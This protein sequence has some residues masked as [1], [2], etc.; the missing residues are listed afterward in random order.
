M[1]GE[2]T[3][4]S[5]ALLAAFQTTKCSTEITENLKQSLTVHPEL[6]SLEKTYLL[7]IGSAVQCLAETGLIKT[8]AAA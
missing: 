8:L 3:R 2:E 6:N 1:Y 7:L 4:L 5:F